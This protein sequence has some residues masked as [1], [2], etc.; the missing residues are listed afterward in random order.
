MHGG[1]LNLRDGQ[2]RQGVDIGDDVD[3]YGKVHLQRFFQSPF[4]LAGVFYSDADG[5]HF[6]RDFGKV[7]L[8]EV[9]QFVR[10]F[11]LLAP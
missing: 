11:G 1:E 5:A 3:D 9:P 10:L 4:D 8:G 7:D 2:R 6:F